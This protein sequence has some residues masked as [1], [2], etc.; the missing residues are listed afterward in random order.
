MSINQPFFP[1]Y[2]AQA[3]PCFGR[4]S[5]L[6]NNRVGRFERKKFKACLITQEDFRFNVTVCTG[7]GLTLIIG[8]KWKEFA[9]VYELAVGDVLIFITSKHGPPTTV[10]S[11]NLPIIH[12]CM[13]Y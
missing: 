3:I 7:N 2:I 9:R 8:S 10:F 5:F 12:P 4:A 1:L 11:Y 13:L 6:K